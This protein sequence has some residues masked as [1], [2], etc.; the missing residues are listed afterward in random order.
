[1]SAS[2]IMDDPPPPY[3]LTVE[4]PGDNRYKKRRI[5]D[6]KSPLSTWGQTPEKQRARNHGPRLNVVTNFSK[7]PALADRAAS[8]ERKAR[9]HPSTSSASITDIKAAIETRQDRPRNTDQQREHPNNSPKHVSKPSGDSPLAKSRV[10]SLR[11]PASRVQELSPSDR[12]VN[13]GLYITPITTDQHSL[14]SELA[15]SKTRDLQ[16]APES[17]GTPSAGAPSII[18]TPAGQLA[19]WSDADTSR[20]DNNMEPS[21]S[22]YSEPWSTPQPAPWPFDAPPIPRIPPEA[23]KTK[24]ATRDIPHD[25]LSDDMRAKNLSICTT[26]EEDEG[27]DDSIPIKRPESG[28]SQLRMLKRSSTESIATKHRSQGWWNTV[29][30]PFWP[31]SPLSIPNS[32][33][34]GKQSGPPSNVS[35]PHDFT[36]KRSSSNDSPTNGSD[37]TS[38]WTGSP[39][40]PEDRSM[41][42]GHSR[43][44]SIPATMPQVTED[45]PP[46]EVSGLAAEYYRACWHDLNSPTPYFNCDNHTCRPNSNPTNNDAR[47]GPVNET[48]RG[49]IDIEEETAK[50]A[51]ELRNSINHQKIRS[52][53]DFHQTPGNR[54][55]AA[56]STALKGRRRPVSEA[57]TI[58][59]LDATPIIEDAHV[60]PVIR[61]VAPM[62][63]TGPEMISQGPP[64]APKES[65]APRTT[66]ASRSPV[67]PAERFNT[68]SQPSQPQPRLAPEFQRGLGLA[69]HE[70]PAGNQDLPSQKLNY[71]QSSLASIVPN[72]YTAPSRDTSHGLTNVGQSPTPY[73]GSLARDAMRTPTPSE[74]PKKQMIAILPPGH[75][76]NSSPTPA[77]AANNPAPRS[78]G[79]PFQGQVNKVGNLTYQKPTDRNP[80]DQRDFVESR[81]SRPSTFFSFRRDSLTHQRSRKIEEYD[82]SS[83]PRGCGGLPGLK[84]L[85]EHRARNTERKQSMSKRK[86]WII[87]AIS[88]GLLFMVIL[89]LILAM[90]LHHKG[91]EQEVQSQWL[92]ITGFPPIPTGV[93]TVVQPDAVRESSGCVEPSTL[94]S[95][96]LPKE[97]QAAVA[98]NDADQ[99]NFRVEIRFRNDSTFDSSGASNATFA[100]R[101]SQ[102]RPRFAKAFI[103]SRI[104][105]ARDSFTNLLFTPMPAPPSRE[106][107]AFL[108]ENTDGNSAPF[109]GEETPF[110]MSFENADKLPSRLAKRANPQP[111]STS[112]AS[113]ASSSVDPFPDLT[114]NIPKPDVNPDGTAA[115]ANLLSYPSAQPL[116]LYDRGKN[117]EHYGFYTYFDRSIFLKSTA[118]LNSSNVAPVPADKDGGAEEDAATVRCT[119]TQTRFLVQIWTNQGAQAQLLSVS[120]NTTVSG[121]HE[122]HGK[123][124]KDLTS[125]SANNFSRPGS[126]PYPVSITLDRHGGNIKSKEIFC[127]GIDDRQHVIDS[128][129]KVQLEDRAFGGKLVN[130]ALGPFGDV[131]VSNAEGG[132][133]GID[134]GTGGCGCVWRNWQAAGGT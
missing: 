107:Q 117:T 90:T 80:Y 52:E 48:S 46:P 44:M 109:E 128:Q 47:G 129:K 120:N 88:A 30:S 131:K 57:T 134:G 89:I 54:F 24:Q 27:P 81:K 11:R 126:F 96:A 133:G 124:P 114:S 115:P 121:S 100:R 103:R 70:G 101:D 91:D 42:A 8:Y 106:D 110:F 25:A 26:F 60:A 79:S 73:T 33:R 58:E 59:D 6:R 116:K 104:L 38:I 2:I 97:Q 22:V 66:V 17:G 130:P 61:G 105:E 102:S 39:D 108:G 16:P 4:Q 35:P 82:K 13:I 113:S 1:M 45:L 23:L 36:R 125:S 50:N 87:V 7:P 123:Q 77:P 71:E 15:P 84:T 98:P 37:H 18:V 92:N 56:F 75:P 74:K 119:W 94:W 51:K 20:P 112:S 78:L 12:L 31:R 69:N 40:E 5:S 28:D 41:S 86:K 72:P 32:L 19:P 62:D 65:P 43:S 83:H 3:Q 49:L 68:V 132:P 64:P 10:N 76:L 111:T 127:Y 122:A 99:P 34:I 29:T 9:H 85:L 14:G 67:L 53:E 55:S 21:S 63:A 118:L 93:S 95:C